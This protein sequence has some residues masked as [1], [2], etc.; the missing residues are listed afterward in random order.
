MSDNKPQFFIFN[1]AVEI[2]RNEPGAELLGLK[3]VEPFT[4]L[5]TYIIDTDP[6]DPASVN[7][8]Y[9]GGALFD[10]GGDEDFYDLDDVPAEAKQLLYARLTD[11]GQ[12]DV[13][14]RG[15]VSEFVLQEILP[16]LRDEAKYRDRAHFMQVAGAEFLAYWGR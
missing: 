15:M 16:S 1:A 4:R 6:D 10:S 9:E 14:V 13:Q 3:F 7:I 12:G 2:A 11:L 8:S 5:E